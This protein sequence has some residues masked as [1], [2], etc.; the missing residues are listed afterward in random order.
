VAGAVGAVCPGES[1]DHRRRFAQFHHGSPPTPRISFDRQG[2]VLEV[3]V[4]RSRQGGTER[5]AVG[6]GVD[7]CFGGEEPGEELVA[8][9]DPVA[10]HD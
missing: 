1:S 8:E 3:R 7:Q 4:R 9:P 5:G 2:V 6:S 10:F